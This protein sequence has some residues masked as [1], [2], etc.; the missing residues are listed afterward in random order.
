MLRGQGY[1]RTHPGFELTPRQTS[2]YLRGNHHF[3]YVHRKTGIR[4]ELHWRFG[5]NRHLFPLRFGDLWRKRQVL[6]LGGVAVPALS[7]TDTILLLCTHGANHH[8]YR[9]FW[10]NDVARLVARKA[11][12]DWHGLMVDADRLGLSRVVAEG[13]VLG[14][15][16]LGSPLPG[17]VQVY[18][19]ADKS[20]ERLTAMAL[21][22]IYRTDGPSFKPFTRPYVFDKMRSLL[23]RK[24]LRYRLGGFA[25]M[26]GADRHYENWERVP[27][28]DRLFPLYYLVRPVMWF[29]RWYVLKS[30]VYRESATG[31][32]VR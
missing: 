19:A 28:P 11:V 7:C 13:L 15:F 25:A 23:L 24:D 21:Y 22:L 17:P 30:R 16:L 32:N 27:L 10:L 1:E 18:A 14:N 6:Q 26:L 29:F 2:A 12:V 5:Q 20:L 8:W 9:L 4:V 3:G 31:R